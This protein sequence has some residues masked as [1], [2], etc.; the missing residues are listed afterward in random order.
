MSVDELYAQGNDL[1]LLVY[2]SEHQKASVSLLH[3][4]AT[5]KL[6]HN[7]VGSLQFSAVCGFNVS[8]SVQSHFLLTKF[9]QPGKSAP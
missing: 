7:V 6:G 8:S 3:Q 5:T 9:S 4:V 1:L 2:T